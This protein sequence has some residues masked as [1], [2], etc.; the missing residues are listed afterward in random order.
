MQ[1]R[2]VVAET[3][4]SVGADVR[5]L[6]ARLLEHVGVLD[7]AVLQ[8]AD[9]NGETVT[10][11]YV[12]GPG[13]LT[14]DDLR[15]W[16]TTAGTALQPDAVVRVSGIPLSPDGSVDDAVLSSLAVIDGNAIDR[17]R[18]ALRSA[19]GVAAAEVVS[20]W[21]APS[22]ATLRVEELL[23]GWSASATVAPAGRAAKQSTRRT[24]DPN[25]PPSISVGG[26]ILWDAEPPTQMSDLLAR[27][28][29]RY[30]ENTVTCVEHDGEF[31]FTYPEL[32]NRAERIMAGL[33]SAGIRA[34]DIVIFQFDRNPDFVAAF[35]GCVLGGFVPAPI[36]VSVMGDP[37]SPAATKL[38]NAWHLLGCPFVLTSAAL[39]PSLTSLKEA[40][41]IPDLKTLTIETMAQSPDGAPWHQTKPDDLALLLLTSGSTGRPK[42]VTQTQGALVAYVTGVTQRHGFTAGDVSLN[43]FPL[44][45]VGGIVM[46]HLR[47]LAMGCNQIQ[48]RTDYILQDVLRWLDLIERFRVTITWA[49]NFAFA[50][51]N[52]R[53]DELASRPRNLSSLGFI[54]NAGE[55][56]VAATT[57]RFLKRLIPHG[58]PE[59]A[60]RPSWGMSET[61]SAETFSPPFRLEATSD[62]DEFVE[63]GSPNPGFEIRIVNDEHRVVQEGVEGH[64]EVRGPC[65]TK[66]YLNN[67]EV[68]ATAFA[69]DGWFRT[70][71]LGRL[72]SGRLTITGRE[73][74][75]IIVNG[76]NYPAHEVESA[77]EDVAGVTPTFTAAFA[78]RE[79]AA[80]T[81]SLAIAFHT[82][83]EKDADVSD[84]LRRIRQ[85]V[86]ERVGVVPRFM[87]PVTQDDIPKTAIGKIQRSA[88]TKRFAEGGFETIVKRSEHLTQRAETIPDW[89]F[90]PVWRQRAL[91]S[92]KPVGPG[93]TVVIVANRSD[94]VGAIESYAQ[95]TGARVV[96]TRGDDIEQ[97]VA[98]V[99]ARERLIIM[100]GDTRDTTVAVADAPDVPAIALAAAGRLLRVV[101]A[102]ASSR[103]ESAR[104][105]LVAFDDRAQHVVTGDRTVVA[106]ASVIGILK[107][108]PSEHPEISVRHVDLPAGEPDDVA[109]LL[110]DEAGDRREESEVAYRN[111]ARWVRRLANRP[112]RPDSRGY[113][114]GRADGFYLVTGGLG[115]VGVETCRHLLRS[116]DVRLLLI[117]RRPIEGS[118]DPRAATLASLQELGTVQYEAADVADLASL[119]RV[120]DAASTE[121]KRPLAGVIHLAGVFEPRLL[122]DETPASLAA[123]LQAK[124][125]GG[126]N[127]HRLLLAHP[128]ARLLVFSS[129]NGQMGGY[130]AGAYAM[131]NAFLD[132]IVE[133]HVAELGRTAHSL[134]WSLWD[135]VGISRE[136]ALKDSA[137]RRGY[138]AIP[139]HQGIISLDACAGSEP[140]HILIGLD[141][142]NPH[143][144]RQVDDAPASEVLAAR[145]V[146]NG[147]G[148]SVMPAPPDDRF[149]KPIPNTLREVKDL[150]HSSADQTSASFGNDLERAIAAVWREVL[151]T[152][153]IGPNENFF[154]AGGT[155]L[156]VAT[157]SRKLQ[158]ALGRDVAMTDIYRFPT[159][160]LLAGFYGGDN[161]ADAVGLDDSEE[162]GKA[163]RAQRMQRRKRA[164]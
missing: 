157:A 76:V 131:A 56:I 104:S 25:A 42:A 34:G 162:R 150:E 61:C 126:W 158:Q 11:A 73:K 48:V 148:D 70:G 101:K 112:A 41:G 38:R 96:V 32:K 102:L 5:A 92:H 53:S 139:A 51:V 100:L 105:E 133:H 116:S 36:S 147:A 135:A 140:G 33:R 91:T 106:N 127:I 109:R 44:D 141:G 75:E 98:T 145:W 95:G 79:P 66:G 143:V 58:L 113:A 155:S 110:L 89:F 39:E 123:S 93:C 23:P 144:R 13:S 43:W 52:D 30:P 9:R 156:L 164:P 90:R 40:L 47:D 118:T 63:V 81:D 54:L 64:L 50:L 29:A 142:S 67:P 161:I 86:L 119:E 122:A 46:F 12:A 77:V 78:V 151:S 18:A 97:M 65:V 134:G 45:H 163:R 15:A 71:D 6:E 2:S 159:L 72:V 152:G 7:C 55:A 26:P 31:V 49:P 16:S 59:T 129:V 74:G 107:T 80:D 69:D 37:A 154:D 130:G 87:L 68:N 120:V 27:T 14:I 84:L 28:A 124:V 128:A 35:W 20:E 99:A 22:E 17:Y 115:G 21:Q 19:P 1:S 94:V 136:Y 125:Q 60:M 3:S 121:W 114:I 83:R 103:S 111:G 138:R 149:G 160:R 117:G 82:Q 132:A 57:R 88:L 62:A 24:L 4:N 146:P 10:I 8:R 137:T 108:V 85:T 153:T